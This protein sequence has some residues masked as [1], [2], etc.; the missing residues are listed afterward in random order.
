MLTELS[1]PFTNEGKK[2]VF[3]IIKEVGMLLYSSSQLASY[4]HFY[5]DLS[6]CKKRM[7]ANGN[8]RYMLYVY[9]VRETSF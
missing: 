9:I 6:T 1:Y 8:R 5:C 2:N 3:Q 4:S 7:L